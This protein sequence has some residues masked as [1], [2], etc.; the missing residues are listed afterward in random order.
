LDFLLT[1]SLLKNLRAIPASQILQEYFANFIKS[2]NPNGIGLPVW[3][4]AQTSKAV[5]VMHIDV[6]TGSEPEKNRKR[7]LFLE[8][9]LK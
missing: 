2:G 8:S 1:R 9:T 7:Y 3:Y 6:N 4:P 5:E